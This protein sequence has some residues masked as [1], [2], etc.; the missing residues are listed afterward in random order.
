MEQQ[1]D[2]TYLR[3]GVVERAAAVGIA[4][5]GI[6]TGI[7]LAAW[8]VSF[9][10][11]Y[12]PPEIAVRIANP[13]LRVIQEAPLTVTQDKPFVIAQPEPL[14]IDTGK[15]TIKVEQPS[16]ISRE[17]ND[18]KAATGEVIRREVTVFSNVKHGPGKVVTGWNYKDGS[19]GVPLGQY[20]Y[21]TVPGVDHSQRR[22]DI[23]SNGVR[24]PHASSALV[25]DLEEAL[26]KCQ[27]WQG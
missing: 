11:R 4:A 2:S 14:K 25:P 5:V 18:I 1:L 15:V 8:G 26:A 13:E 17:A 3:P 9:L 22:V 23:A 16:S 7:L 12:A 21:Y 19:D 20:C 27:W 10:W 24:L 6:G